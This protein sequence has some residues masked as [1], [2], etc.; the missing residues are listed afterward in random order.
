[1]NTKTTFFSYGYLLCFYFSNAFA[2]ELH[3]GN[4]SRMRLIPSIEDYYEL[5]EI[6]EHRIKADA[7]LLCKEA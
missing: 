1:M 4:S 6:N 3:D 5:R 7:P 2:M